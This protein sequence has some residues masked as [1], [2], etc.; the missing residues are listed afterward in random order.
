MAIS[1]IRRKRVRSR[2]GASLVEAAL[3]LLPFM[4][5]M[6][7]IIDFAMPIFLNSLMANAA[8]EGSRFAITHQTSYNGV[9]Y[10]T[11]TAAIKAVVQANSMGFLAG[12]LGASKIQVKYFASAPPFGEQTGVG[13]N[14]PGNIVEVSVS[15]YNWL[16]IAP[17]WRTANPLSITAGSSGR[18]EPLSAGASPPAP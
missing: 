12:P 18:L 13:A 3:V 15:G 6:L 9:N 4:A 17:L 5:L 1:R 10:T 7:A 16:W 14:K 8:R 11:H 2:R